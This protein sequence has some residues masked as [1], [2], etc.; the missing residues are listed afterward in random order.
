[1]AR[2]NEKMPIICSLQHFEK[3]TLGLYQFNYGQS[4][5]CFSIG[6]EQM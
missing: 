5:V 6:D 3:V 2:S 4:D 1:M